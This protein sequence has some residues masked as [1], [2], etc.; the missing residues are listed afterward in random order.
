MFDPSLDALGVGSAH[1]PAPQPSPVRTLAV[2]L[3][4]PGQVGRALLEQLRDAAPRLATR[5][6]ALPLCAVAN[7]RRMHLNGV[8]SATDLEA[9]SQHMRAQDHH[10]VLVDCTA[11]TQVAA[12]YPQ[13]LGVGI[14]VVTPNKHTGSGD[15]RRWHAATHAARQ[16]GAQWRYEATVGA[17]LPVV[18]TLREMIDTGDTPTCIEGLFSGTLAWLFNRFDGSQ[19][20]STLV[21]E[22]RAAGYTEPDPREDLGGMDVA[23]KL[24]ILAREAGW[25]L[26]LD[27]V[28]VDGLV[29]AALAAL[30][31]EQALAHLHEID[32]PLQQRLER[33]RAAGHV[34][35]YVGRLDASG[36]ARVALEALPAD[37]AFAHGRLTDNIIALHS[38]RY[39]ANPLVIQGPGAGPEVTAAGVFADL[40]RVAASLGAAA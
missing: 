5:G 15:L 19:P 4:G 28:Q 21:H 32:A 3:I 24:V 31:L 39:C 17:G 37:H 35:R 6:L 9:L 7:S 30:P 1:L 29:P 20:F 18:Q 34:L 22:A 8:E 10:A 27:Q 36:G 14:H 12:R 38:Q 26:S 2:G 16:S 11:S 13:W 33:A 25:D 40:L 23:R